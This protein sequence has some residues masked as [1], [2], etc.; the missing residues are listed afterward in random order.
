MN[1]PAFT[2][3]LPII[4]ISF[5]FHMLSNMLIDCR[6]ALAYLLRLQSIEVNYLHT[7]G[8]LGQVSAVSVWANVIVES[9]HFP[10]P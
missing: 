7:P 9:I 8:I 10:A 6:E 1:P 5:R 3:G 2:V 4:L